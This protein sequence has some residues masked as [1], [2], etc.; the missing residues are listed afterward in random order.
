M[1]LTVVTDGF[2]SPLAILVIAGLCASPSL[3]SSASAQEAVASLRGRVVDQQGGVL[4]GTIV[5]ARS[6]DS[7]LFRE[8][9]TESDGAFVLNGMAPGRYRI[10]AELTGF[11]KY[12]RTGVAL[13]VGRSVTFDIV[14]EV[15]GIGEE[16]DVRAELA[17][18]D[19]TSK[20]VGGHISNQELVELPSLN[21]NFTG[22]LALLPGATPNFA[23]D[24]FA[25][26][27][28]SIGGQSSSNVAFT[29]D[30]SSN[31]DTFIGGQ[32]GAQARIPIEA[33]AE[34]QMLTG[35]FDAEFGGTSG[36][37]VN[38]VSKQGTNRFTGSA[39]G[40][41]KDS[42]LTATNYFAKK[43]KLAKPDSKEYQM[44]GTLGGPIVPNKAHFF[45]SLERV[46]LDRGI[47]LSIPA[48]PSLS[49]SETQE[50]RVW[51]YFVRVDH[52]VNANHTWGVRWLRE[53]SPQKNLLA[54][55]RSAATAEEEQDDDQTYVGTFNS[56]LGPSSFNQFKLAYTREEAY[57]GSDAFFG[58]DDSFDGVAPTLEFQTFRDQQ[59]PR[60]DLWSQRAYVA[61]NTFSWYVPDLLGNHDFKVGAEFSQEEFTRLISSELNGSFL[62]SGN[63]AFN[64]ADPRTYPDQLR[65]RVPGAQ[66]YLIKVQRTS[67]FFQDKWR[68]ISP[69]TLTLGLRYELENA[70]VNESWN[71]AF[72][73]PKA[74]PIDKNNLM[75]RVGFSYALDDQGRTVVRGGWGLFFQRS[76]WLD[77]SGLFGSRAFS[78]SFTV[79]FPANNRDPGPSAGRFPTDPMLVNGPTVNY[80]LLRAL[81][82]AGA[83]QKNAGQ[84]F[85]DNPDRRAPYTN[86]VSLGIQRAFSQHF[87]VSADVI[88]SAS[89]SIL[90]RRD[91]NPGLR[92]DTSR[93]GRVVR[94]DPGYVTNVYRFENLG[95]QDYRSLQVQIEKRFSGFYGARVSYTL[96]KATGNVASNRIPVINT[97]LLGDLRLDLNEGA[98]DVDRRHN[99]V[100]SG[101]LAI[102]H[103]GGLRFSAVARYL[104]GSPFTIHDTTTDPDRNGILLDPIASG[105]YT[106]N[107]SDAITVDNDEGPNGA[108][109]PSFFQLDGR[110][111][112]RI[113]L[114]GRRSVE[115]FGEVLNLTNR[116]NFANPGGDRRAADFLIPTALQ[117]GG[118]VRTAQLGARLAF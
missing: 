118:P 16:V 99:L 78:D 4:P 12:V 53:L 22:Y 95:S 39:F 28:V 9:T 114:K 21:R 104:S 31:N 70:P 36:G 76:I 47:T 17:V 62:F 41:F 108:Y 29:F 50:T 44:G 116:S 59:S 42:A 48:R 19:V 75:P 94:I 18:I 65:I 74:Y 86:Q 26:D 43:N 35:Q 107:G 72:S 71:P 46:I 37:I 77:M 61:A 113:G 63:A 90:A 97:Q 66:T 2:R 98:L 14:M 100:V 92:V 57:N 102:P 96:S 55:N 84:V 115:I 83:T 1:R 58:N 73:D 38:A 105:E 20:A 91:L 7:G 67:A 40:F 87:S 13:A 51:N 112:Y 64:A 111:S 117:G 103:T 56:V 33:I 15:G 5:V 89:R 101:T 79:T 68:P 49:S 93:T 8:A 10:E 34:F 54:A 60:A 69:L 109:G 81:Y 52:Q 25:A 3:P 24:S 32:S 11:R 6:E 106:G 23:T 110:M 45:A 80:T 82:P 30:G 85:F 27:S 88:N